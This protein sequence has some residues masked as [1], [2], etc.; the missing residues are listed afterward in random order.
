MRKAPRDTSLSAHLARVEAKLDRLTTLTEQS[1]NQHRASQ[2]DSRLFLVGWQAI[3]AA[4]RLQPRTLRTYRRYGFPVFRWGRHVVTTLHMIE[5]WLVDRERKK[6]GLS[7][8]AEA[9]IQKL[10]GMRGWMNEG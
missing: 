4:V 6:R 1:F 10:L 8:E 3:A 2:A 9:T 7:D 5:L